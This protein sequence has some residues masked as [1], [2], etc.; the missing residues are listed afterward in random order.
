[1]FGESDAQIED[2]LIGIP[3]VTLT[4]DDQVLSIYELRLGGEWSRELNSGARFVSQ[5]VYEAQLWNAPP[6]A[7]GLLDSSI[8]F[9]GPALSIAIER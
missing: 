6:M 3:T 8:G 9:V 2:S 4:A 1:M 5:L 7:L